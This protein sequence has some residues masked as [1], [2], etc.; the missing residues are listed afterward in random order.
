[1][2]G[3]QSGQEQPA[4]S[5][6]RT[7][8]SLEAALPQ[9]LLRLG[10]RSVAQLEEAEVST[11]LATG[12]GADTT[13]APKATGARLIGADLRFASAERVY[14]AL[15]DLRGADLLGANMWSA[16]LRGA[17]LTGAS[18]VA[19]LLFDADF[20]KVRANAAPVADRATKIG[21][22]VYLDTLF[23]S[24]TSFASAN[25]RY[26]R[27]NGGDLREASFDGALLQGANFAHARLTHATFAGADLDGTDFRDAI[28]LVP[29]QILAAR[30]VEALYDSTLLA[31]LKARSP[32]RFVG[33]D[34]SAIAVETERERLSGEDEP[35]TLNADD[36]RARERLVRAGYDGGPAGSPSRG[37]IQ[38]WLGAG[39]RASD[40]VPYGCVVARGKRTAGTG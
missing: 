33:Y 20:R 13:A 11:R 39:H 3:K 16:D 5:L 19:T 1:V 25:L 2:A 24:R 29:D 21:A 30:H 8:P 32:E 14:L 35:D 37:D 7:V 31:A 26:A 18:L 36:L 22:V 15:S 9:L 10:M 4:L 6:Q 27:F 34:A 17:N 12:A 38:A 28:G 40:P 23:C